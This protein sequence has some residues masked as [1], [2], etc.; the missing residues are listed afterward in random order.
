MKT[1][2]DN[3]MKNEAQAYLDKNVQSL[4]EDDPGKAYRNLKKMAAQPGDCS[5]E[6]SFDLLSHLEENLTS[7][8]S[9]ERI[10]Q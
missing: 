3:K 6:S 2:Y 7:Q 8:E 9:V 4:K 1:T 5:R 10:A